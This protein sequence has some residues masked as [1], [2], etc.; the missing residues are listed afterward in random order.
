MAQEVWEEGLFLFRLSVLF[1]HLEMLSP[2]VIE[3][4][5][6]FFGEVSPVPQGL[7]HVVDTNQQLAYKHR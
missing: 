4:G 7:H 6:F 1:G 3:F 5:P 2:F